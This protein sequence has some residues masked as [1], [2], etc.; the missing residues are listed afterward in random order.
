MIA[1]TKERK[2]FRVPNCERKI[3]AKLLDAGGPPSR[4]SV[5]QQLRVARG[6]GGYLCP[7]CHEGTD[8]F[9]SRIQTNIGGDLQMLDGAVKWPRAGGHVCA[10]LEWGSP[11]A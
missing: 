9:G 1:G 6:C 8:K 2:S 3:A 11:K 5:Q 4:V 10:R 7:G